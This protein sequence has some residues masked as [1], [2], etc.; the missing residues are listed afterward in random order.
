M[1]VRI[2]ITSDGRDSLKNVPI[3]STYVAGGADSKGYYI[4]M[5]NNSPEVKKDEKAR[6]RTEDTIRDRVLSLTQDKLGILSSRITPEADLT[7]DLNMDSLDGVELIMALEEEFDIEIQD[8]DMERVKTV[9]DAIN[10]IC[11]RLL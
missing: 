7:K 9:Q 4:F 11:K 2:D 10:Y 3:G 5:E 6:I 8:E 1:R